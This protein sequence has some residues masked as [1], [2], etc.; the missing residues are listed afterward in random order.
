MLFRTN[1]FF[2]I[3]FS[4]YIFGD[5]CKLTKRCYGWS[6]HEWE[7]RHLH[8]S[9]QGWILRRRG[10]TRSGPPGR[11]KVSHNDHYHSL[12][13]TVSKHRANALLKISLILTT[14]LK[15]WSYYLMYHIMK[16]TQRRKV[17]KSIQ[18]FNKAA[19][20]DWRDISETKARRQIGPG[21]DGKTLL[22]PEF[23]INIPLN[24]CL[25]QHY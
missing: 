15:S 14:F 13:L 6:K 12:N 21:R 3:W 25:V 2:R 1:N 11:E 23:H 16:Q 17:L 24:Q 4:C 22:S 18:L 7:E 10:L 9:S 8:R 19:P 5:N 20:L